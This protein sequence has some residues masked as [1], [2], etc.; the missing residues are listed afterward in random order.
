MDI[1]QLSSKLLD[2][3]G[4]VSFALSASPDRDNISRSIRLCEAQ[5]EEKLI[6]GRNT[7]RKLRLGKSTA[8]SRAAP[9]D[10]FSAR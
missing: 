5:R 2:T 10:N 9:S 1:V 4:C 7:V 8:F 6:F 3:A